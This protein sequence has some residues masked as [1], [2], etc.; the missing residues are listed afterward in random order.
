MAIAERLEKALPEPDKTKP[1]PNVEERMA[2]GR[3]RMRDGASE[4]NLPLKFWRGNQYV[5]KGEDGI[6]VNQNTITLN[7]GQGKPRWR[8]RQVRNLFVDVVAHEVSAATQRIPSYEVNPSTSDPEDISAA[9]LGEKV[10]RYGYDKWNLR[11]VSERVVTYA[12]VAD[13]GFAWPFWDSSIGPF[14]LDAEGS[15]GEGEV[16]IRVFGPNEVYWEPGLKFDES[17]W[18]AVEQARSVED[19]YAMEGYQGG[20][21]TPDAAHDV[22]GIEHNRYTQ[23]TKLVLVTEYLE[24]PSAKNPQGRWLTLANKKVIVPERPYPC[25]D[26][27][28]N[29]VDEPVLHKLSYFTDPDSDRDMGLGRHLIDPQRTIN[30]CINKMLEWK[31]LAMNPQVIIRNGEFKQRLTDEPGAVYH[32]V[33]SGEVTWRPVPDMPAA[34]NNI[35][36]EAVEDMARIAAQ[37]DIPSQVESG[38][39]IQALIEKD[40]NRRAS[41]IANVAEFHSRLMRHCLYLVQKHYTEPR[42]LKIRGL[43]AAERIT[44]FK[45][46]QLRGQADVSVFPGS[47]EPRSRANI[48]QKI[49]NFADR[50]WIS[51]EAAMAAINGGTAEALILSYEQDVGRAS[52]IIQKIREGPEVLFNQPDRPRVGDEVQRDPVT[53]MP[54]IDPATGQPPTV[55]GWMPRPFDRVSI[56]KTVFEDHMKTSEWDL[57]SP[58]QK[59]AE[60]LYY[61]EILN[62]EARNAAREAAMQQQMASDLGTAN[63]ARPPSAEMP[64]QP[65]AQDAPA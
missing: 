5:F 60:L 56:H 37:N 40:Q 54:M 32:A 48:E 30:D 22:D 7:N 43:Y 36:A 3:G 31:N 14:H 19:V 58:E 64:D 35:K 8:V 52:E 17:R 10:A 33:G 55:P 47:L 6:L 39:G 42:L 27:D 25:T 59:E 38:R 16:G 53:G 21:L 65:G 29:A 28:G 51:P 1:P 26:S 63:A 57:F 15:I 44:G 11:S 13:E 50:G 49:L 24:R 2:R 4:R 23:H 9:R 62:I 41:F 20:V 45:G 18:H 12:V 46:A 34:L 61:E